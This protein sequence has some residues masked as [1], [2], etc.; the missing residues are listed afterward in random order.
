MSKKY[1]YLV[2]EYI[3]NGNAQVGQDFHFQSC[4]LKDVSPRDL[5]SA[6]HRLGRELTSEQQ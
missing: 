2:N 4:L 6:P 3:P 1:Y 5:L